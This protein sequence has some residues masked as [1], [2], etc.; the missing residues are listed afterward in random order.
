M[1]ITKSQL[2]KERIEKCENC[3]D[4]YRWEKYGFCDK[5]EEELERG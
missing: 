1:S 2:D 3:P 5:C 4:K